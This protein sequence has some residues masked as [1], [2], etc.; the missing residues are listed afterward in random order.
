MR[1]IDVKRGHTGSRAGAHLHRGSAAETDDAGFTLIEIM[2]VLM[3]LAILLAIAIPTFL[4]TTAVA[5][6][7]AAQANLN[8]AYTDA[9]VQYENNGQTYWVNGAQDALGFANLLSAAQLSETFH[10]GSAGTTTATG[11][12]GSASVV[13]VSVSLDGNGLV[14]ANYAKPGTCFYIV[15]NTTGL[16]PASSS[17]APYTGATAITTS[18]VVATAGTLGL[19]T[20]SGV[21][22]VTVKGDYTA[23][24]CNAYSPETSGSPATVQYL[25]SGYPG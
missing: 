2:I 17:V 13:S 1:S 6:S 8:T 23:N 24:D 3:I 4:S 21:N 7:R 19:P 10:V 12:S 18:P 25:T 15:D 11:S 22:Y 16:S 9:K 5:T 14:L 20:G